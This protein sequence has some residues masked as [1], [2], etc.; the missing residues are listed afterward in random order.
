MGQGHDGKIGGAAGQMNLVIRSGV[1]ADC[2]GGQAERTEDMEIAGDDPDRMLSAACVFQKDGKAE[3]HVFFSGG[4]TVFRKNTVWVYSLFQQPVFHSLCLSDGYRGVEAPGD[5]NFGIRV[6]F[7]IGERPF[8]T[9]F[10]GVG[11]TFSV[12]TGAQDHD[13]IQI[14]RE[15]LSHSPQ[16]H[17]FYQK[18]EREPGC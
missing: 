13:I 10:Q 7:D 8:E 11:R 17:P 5:K 9:E 18:K 3:L 1:L 2:A 4:G 14:I 16:N 6:G 12:E 15:G